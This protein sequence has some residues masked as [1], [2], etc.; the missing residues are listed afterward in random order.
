MS[1][2]L[3]GFTSSLVSFDSFM[4]LPR[5]RRGFSPTLEALIWFF[6]P[7]LCKRDFFAIFNDNV[8]IFLTLYSI[9]V[10][11]PEPSQQYMTSINVNHMVHIIDN[12]SL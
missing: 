7:Y 12:L 9:S 5:F 4:M 2:I 3:V 6:P 10:V 1:L 11:F 8:D